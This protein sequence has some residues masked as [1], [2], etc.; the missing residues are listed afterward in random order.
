MPTMH[1]AKR[2]SRR[3]ESVSKPSRRSVRRARHGGTPP[4]PIV[5]AS[6][7]RGRA[8]PSSG[9]KVA[10]RVGK[11]SGARNPASLTPVTPHMS[12]LAPSVEPNAAR[13][14]G[15]VFSAGTVPN[16]TP[17]AGLSGPRVR[18]PARKAQPEALSSQEAPC[19]AARSAD[20]NVAAPSPWPVGVG[21]PATS[22]ATHTVGA[23][24]APE[25]QTTA[26]APSA[27]T[28]PA[29]SPPVAPV[30][31]STSA[32]ADACAQI[33]ERK[34]SAASHGSGSSHASDSSASGSVR[35]SVT[36]ARAVASALLPAHG[37]KPS[38]VR[39]LWSS[40]S[41]GDDAGQPNAASAGAGFLSPPQSPVD[42]DTDCLL[43]PSDANTSA[44]SAVSSPELERAVAAM[45]A[46][47]G[48]SP[49]PSSL[50]VRH[51]AISP[52]VAPPPVPRRQPRGGRGGGSGRSA[53]RRP[54]HEHTTPKVAVTTKQ[55]SQS[56]GRRVPIRTPGNVDR[57]TVHTGPGRS[58][59]L[60]GAMRSPS[61]SHLTTPPSGRKIGASTCV[62]VGLGGA[63]QV[64]EDQVCHPPRCPRTLV[65]PRSP[66]LPCCVCAVRCL[67][68]WR[69]DEYHEGRGGRARAPCGC[70]GGASCGGAGEAACDV[71][72]PDGRPQ[73][74]SQG[75][76]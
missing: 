49:A 75:Q 5:S 64:H 61:P 71:P 30:A 1:R 53:T 23:D 19:E 8:V 29:P 31:T 14:T 41:D 17:M 65:A 25:G 28:P 39:R 35:S 54:G 40:P 43:S 68:G 66:A 45:E 72:L 33:S 10:I 44:S 3:S 63:W 47:D 76:A 11:R 42:G 2:T 34:D 20:S 50:V 57:R 69:A 67:R 32:H 48:G 46:A 7:A 55:G 52:A 21:G 26:P 12:L 70:C 15:R 4:T 38:I 22:P 18:K 58:R 36:R 73:R 60:G 24:I 51:G 9:D 56:T 13:F 62:A 16:V 59:P 37:G 27:A 6:A 74:R